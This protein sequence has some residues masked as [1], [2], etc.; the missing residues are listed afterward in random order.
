[1]KTYKNWGFS[2]LELCAVFVILSILLGIF[3]PIV[4][5]S[6]SSACNISCKNNLKQLGIAFYCY[7]IDYSGKLPHGDRDSD[8]GVNYCWFDVLDSYLTRENLSGIKQCPSWKGYKSGKETSDEHS[9]KMNGGLCPNE[10]PYETEQNEAEHHWYWPRIWDIQKK[11]STVLL[12]DGRMDA[13]YNT[14]TDTRIY[15][16]YLDIANRHSHGANILTVSGEVKYALSKTKEIEIGWKNSQ[17][18]IWQPYLKNIKR[19]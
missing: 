2:L 9:I 5:S 4:H 15:H 13:P 14:H 8:T 1:M 19:K 7:S 3:L 11:S 16:G 10:R 17:G 12:V 18:F 6:Y